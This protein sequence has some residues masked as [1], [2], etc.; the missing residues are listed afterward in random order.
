MTHP[1]LTRLMDFLQQ[2]PTPYHAVHNIKAQLLDA[3]FEELK[4]TEHWQTPLDKPAFITRN[5]SS[6]IAFKAGTHS[7]TKNGWR[8]VGAHTDSPCLKLKPNPDQTNQDIHQ[9]GVEV[10]GGVLLRSWFDRDLALAGRVTVQLAS[11][12]MHSCLIDSKRP[13]A[14][15]P[16]LAIH[17]HSDKHMKTFN[18][19]NELPPVVALD[20]EDFSLEQW[21]V[22]QLPAELTSDG[23]PRLIAHEL[24]LYDAQAPSLVGMNEEW[25]C[26]ARLDNLLSTFIATDT[27]IHSDSPWPIMMVT[28]DHEEVGSQSAAGAQGSFLGDVLKRLH[29]DTHGTYVQTIQH[30]MFLSV[31]NAHAVHPNYSSRHDDQHLAPMGG[32]LVI[33]SN[34]NQRYATNS[35]TAGLLKQLAFKHE[36]P[37]Q[38]FVVRADMGCGSTIGPITAAQLGIATA[39]CGIPQ[40]AMHSIRETAGCNDILNGHALI[41]AFLKSE[42]LHRPA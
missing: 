26:S 13:I 4:E 32:G 39:D 18:A 3:G 42:R 25:L 6:L 12:A 37:I 29:G 14:I 10:Y 5:D 9:W 38:E 27:M 19:Q 1:T 31:D 34:A 8:M 7:P 40:W 16:N 24:S 35:L 11:G 28:N 17:L 22:E 21:V 36:L 41:A 20:S 2:S 33:K 15:I 30:S 23:P